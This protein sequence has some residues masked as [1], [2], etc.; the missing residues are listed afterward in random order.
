MKNL[1]D[2]VKNTKLTSFTFIWDYFQIE[3]ERIKINV[4]ME[5]YFEV[6]DELIPFDSEAFCHTLRKL[7]AK[8]V[9]DVREN[10][11]WI[12]I[13]FGEGINLK[14]PLKGDSPGD[15]AYIIFDN[16]NHEFDVI[17]QK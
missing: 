15:E 14:L 6:Q 1:I 10:E 2:N 12:N 11:L 3:F 17:Y 4:M 9:E 5:P 7:I 16:E 8:K 13:G